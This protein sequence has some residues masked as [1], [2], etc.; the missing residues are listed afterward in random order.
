MALRAVCRPAQTSRD[1]H[2]HR[3]PAGSATPAGAR[4]LSARHVD[5]QC[6]ADLAKVP[7][8]STKRIW[9]RTSDVR[10]TK[11]KLSAPSRRFLEFWKQWATSAPC[12]HSLSTVPR[13]VECVMAAD[14]FAWGSKI[15]IGGFLQFS[16]SEPIWFS[17][18]F[19]QIR[20]LC[21]QA[22]LCSSFATHGL[23]LGRA[24]RQAS[25]TLPKGFA[26]RSLSSPSK[27]GMTTAFSALLPSIQIAFRLPSN[28]TI[29][30]RRSS[31][32]ALQQIMTEECVTHTRQT[33]KLF[34]H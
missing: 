24:L 3:S 34:C 29:G 22:L 13:D 5:L 14:A 7:L 10:S 17:E 12:L 33:P 27:T 26:S 16:G 20:Q 25:V 30:A 6:R 18:R 21:E 23:G 1:L 4:L 8:T 15:G 19:F 28:D 2:F 32:A 31:N 9:M 11:R